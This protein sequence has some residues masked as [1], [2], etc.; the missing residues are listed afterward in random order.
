MICRNAE[1][2]GDFAVSE[3]PE[4]PNEKDRETLCTV[5]CKGH[6]DSPYDVEDNDPPA[7]APPQLPA[8][9]RIRSVLEDQTKLL[10]ECQNDSAYKWPDHSVSFVM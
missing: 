7:I 1:K 4:Y 3:V 2:H 5:D 8:A 10:I 9:A 6:K